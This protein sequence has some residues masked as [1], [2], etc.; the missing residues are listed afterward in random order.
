M[1]LSK[2]FLLLIIFITL[3][4]NLA[5]DVDLSK[6]I[7]KE[8]SFSVCNPPGK[9]LFEYPWWR[10][11]QDP[12]LDRFVELVKQRSLDFKNARLTVERFKLL[13]NV[14]KSN[15]W[16]EISLSTGGTRNK[17][18]L[19][20]FLPQS[21]S[22]KNTNYSFMFNVSY[23]IDLFK[24]LSNTRK[25][26]YYGF[27]KSVESQ[28]ALEL[29][30]L[31]NAV[32][33]YFRYSELCFEVEKFREILKTNT[34]IRK[35]DLSSYLSGVVPSET[36]LASDAIVKQ[37][38]N[39]ISQLEEKKLE[40]EQT[41]KNVLSDTDARLK[42]SDFSNFKRNYLPV[43][44]GIPSELLLRRPDVRVAYFDVYSKAC[45]VGIAKANLFPSIKLT[46]SDGFKTTALSLLFQ[47]RSNVW[48]FGMNI[49]QPVFNRGAL[50]NR[51]KISEKDLEI[52]VNNY[53]KT[54]IKAFAEVDYL[55]DQYRQLVKRLNNEKR[56]LIVTKEIESKKF[57]DYLMG[58]G[59]LRGYLLARVNTLNEEITLNRL[60]LSLLIN[61][62]SLY[63]AL[64]G[65]IDKIN[66]LN[67]EVK[68]EK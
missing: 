48:N 35:S 68:N 30:V 61:R 51:L 27:L 26:S 5:P 49:F 55:L 62:V 34:L 4:C 40:L 60:Y 58:T 25:Q 19:R 56:V 43:A 41:I 54:V 38:E 53:R 31:S 21:G 10:E 23:E 8:K 45:M 52:S 59:D 11:F 57:R 1:K 67:L 36:L 22:F 28:K 64:G 29:S 24:K 37:N 13:Y 16:P 2:L 39:A 32:V 63:K 44:S 14:S 42:V 66:N 3:S 65:G 9:S 15:F 47:Q 6:G 50:I 17:T 18:N 46:G 12:D 20:T 7:T 33:L